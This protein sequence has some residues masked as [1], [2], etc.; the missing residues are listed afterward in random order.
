[1]DKHFAVPA[2][3]T[4]QAA[5]E[6]EALRLAERIAAAAAETEPALAAAANV[7]CADCRPQLISG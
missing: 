2:E 6:Q 3:I 1:M 7:A 4:L 5:D